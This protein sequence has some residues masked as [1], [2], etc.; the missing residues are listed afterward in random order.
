MIIR[1][2]GG[3]AMKKRGKKKIIAISVLVAFIVVLGVISS[4]PIILNKANA[5]VEFV[6]TVRAQAPGPYSNRLP[7]LP[8][9][10]TI[11]ECLEDIVNYTIYYFPFGTLGMSYIQGDGY[12]IEKPLT[13]W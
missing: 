6:E 1:I 12:N 4:N 3:N 2:C 9:Y 7:L 11:D 8:I 10:V 5:P 13:G